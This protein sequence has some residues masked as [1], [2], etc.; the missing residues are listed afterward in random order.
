MTPPAKFALRVVGASVQHDTE[1]TVT[2]TYERSIE[3]GKSV[4]CW[5][6]Y[7]DGDAQHSIYV[8][9]AQD[10]RFV[11]ECMYPSAT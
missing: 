9:T 2:C 1:G 6:V 4:L 5:V 10:N 8:G 11:E 7:P 3:H